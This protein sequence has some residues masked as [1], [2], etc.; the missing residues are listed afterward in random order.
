VELAAV[1]PEI[2]RLERECERVLVFMNNP[3]RGQA[4]IN[5]QMLMEQ[6]KGMTNDELRITGDNHNR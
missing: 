3:W 1:I 4:V 5:A 6:L 2:R